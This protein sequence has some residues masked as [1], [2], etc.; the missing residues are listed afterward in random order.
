MLSLRQVYTMQLLL[1][2]TK[3]NE[4]MLHGVCHLNTTCCIQIFLKMEDP[5]SLIT[6]YIVYIKHLEYYE[7]DYL[8]DNFADLTGNTTHTIVVS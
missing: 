1:P 8:R 4:Q 2:A 7:Y 3:L 5:S 6:M